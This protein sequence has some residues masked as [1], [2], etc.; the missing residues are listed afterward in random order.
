M[1]EGQEQNRSEEATPFKLRQARQKGMVARG[2]DLGFVVGLIG[3]AAFVSFAGAAL[4]DALGSTMHRTLVAGIASASD[5]HAATSLAARSL[6]PVFQPVVLF[7][8]TVI[9]VVLLVEVV[10]L[11]GIMFSATPLKPD[12][13]RLNP[14]AGL[15]RLFSKRMLVEAMKSILKMTVYTL[16]AGFSIRR[17]LGGATERIIDAPHLVGALR[18]AG[19]RL[20][21]DFILVAIFFAVLDQVLSRRAFA[22]QMRMSRREV[23]RE[24]KDREGDARLKHRRKQIHAAL[25]EQ[26]KGVGGVKGSDMLVVNPE[27]VAVALVYRSE[28]DAAPRVTAKGRG[29]HAL[30]LRRAAIRWNVPIIQQQPLARALFAT[31]ERD[32]QIGAEHYDQVAELYLKLEADRR[33]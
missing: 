3:L 28:K 26:A 27:H 11:R 5:P 8:G 25:V 31:C 4:M 14:A 18:T 15:K 13:N 24:V 20:L 16:V 9:A 2:L 17:S 32:R 22:K 29:Y 1:A 10:Q 12:F 30:R 33:A 6:W 23:T 19:L 7:G 21:L